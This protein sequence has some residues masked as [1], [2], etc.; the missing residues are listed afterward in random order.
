MSENVTKKTAARSVAIFELFNILERG[1]FLT[2]LP[3]HWRVIVPV[4]PSR[5]KGQEV[6]GVAQ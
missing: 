1:K 2:P 5:L 4:C 3:R 6:H